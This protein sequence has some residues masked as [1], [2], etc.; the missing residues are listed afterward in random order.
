MPTYVE[1]CRAGCAR[2]LAVINILV[3]I[4]HPTCFYDAVFDAHQKSAAVLFAGRWI[5][6]LAFC[7]VFLFKPLSRFESHDVLF[8]HIRFKAILKGHLHK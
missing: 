4:A 5:A 8:K 3:S 1:S 2:H 7:H 6:L